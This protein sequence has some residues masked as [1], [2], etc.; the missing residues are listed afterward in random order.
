MAKVSASPQKRGGEPSK[1][2]LLSL[3]LLHIM[4]P[5]WRKKFKRFWFPFQL[6]SQ[7]Q[8]CV[9]LPSQSIAIASSCVQHFTKRI[10]AKF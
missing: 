6:I 7:V 4:T 1:R 2:F 10:E 9:E 3:S 5:F 8:S